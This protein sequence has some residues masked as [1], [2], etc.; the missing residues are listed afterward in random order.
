MSRYSIEYRLVGRYSIEYAK[1]TGPQGPAGV[2]VTKIP[3]GTLFANSSGEDAFPIA[4]TPSQ[5][6][7]VVTTDSRLSDA[8]PPVSHTHSADAI[9]S[10]ELAKARQHPQTAYLD[11][12]SQTF[13]GDATF[14]T[15]NATTYRIAG[16]NV[17]SSGFAGMTTIQGH[18]PSGAVIAFLNS[19][20]VVGTIQSDGTAAFLGAVACGAPVAPGSYTVATLPS[21]S[22]NPGRITVVT[23]SS[24]TTNGTPVA[25]G[26]S[27]RVLVFSN[28]TT[29]DVVVA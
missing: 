6:N 2:G 26:G 15:A 28:G 4:R 23:N 10:G 9:I 24:V 13:S 18:A 20:T 11:A 21:A 7:L 3:T 1:G 29:W 8:R 25:A 17:L 22:A 14:N 19:A 5:M 27:N 12:A 16:L